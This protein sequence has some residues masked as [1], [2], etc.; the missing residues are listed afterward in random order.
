MLISMYVC[1]QFKCHISNMI[2]SGINN[3]LDFISDVD[4]R[5][6]L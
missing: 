4:N 6:N 3:D 1:I 2:K 5:I